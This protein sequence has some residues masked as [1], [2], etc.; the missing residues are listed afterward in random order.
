MLTA[1]A[2]R[3]AFGAACV[4]RGAVAR[5]WPTVAAIEQQKG[6]NIRLYRVLAA[7]LVGPR[8]A[9]GAAM[10]VTMNETIDRLH[11]PYCY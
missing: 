10:N 1:S 9:G 6:R 4:L 8:P 3:P 7:V 11:V 2:V 5:Q